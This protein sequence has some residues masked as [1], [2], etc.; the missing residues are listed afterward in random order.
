MTSNRIIYIFQDQYPWDV[1]TEKF[2]KTLST[3]HHF[4]DLIC[5]NRENLPTYERIND[6]A[7]IR[8]L[9][10]SNIAGVRNLINT[11]AFF[12][13]FWFS[14]ILRSIKR[15]S[16]KLLIVRDLPLAPL[17]LLISR[18]KSIP[19][20]LDMAEDY[21]AMLKDGFFYEKKNMKDYVIRNPKIYKFIEKIVLPQLD[22]IIVVT[23]ESKARIEKLRVDS[24][25]IWVVSNT[26]DLKSIYGN[27]NILE[28]RRFRELSSFII[29]YVGGLE[30]GRGLDIVIKALPRVK[31]VLPDVLFLIVG[32][33]SVEQKLRKIAKRYNVEKN[34][35]FTG[36][37]ANNNIHN[38]IEASDLCIVPH[39]VTDHT[40]TTIPNKIFDYMANK[41]PVLTSNSISLNKVISECECGM[42]YQHDEPESLAECIHIFK[43]DRIRKQF[44]KK[45][46]DAVT[47]KYNWGCDSKIL[48][49]AIN[50]IKNF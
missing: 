50:S 31:K 28:Y 39:Y 1:R 23:E 11:P 38:I 44:G 17:A 34:I 36:W 7:H 46:F 8:R 21:P 32:K 3:N 16:P 33:G 37:V 47:K 40:N 27:R 4:I 6:N 10:Y 48:L 13:P 42:T 19:V 29:I 20:I 41:K 9:R 2:I 14:L 5:R 26:P 25:K 49:K 18:I 24:H 22:G 12:S 43:D 35:H 30:E 45:G 15:R